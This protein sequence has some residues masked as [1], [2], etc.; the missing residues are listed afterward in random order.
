MFTKYGT[1][2]TP[3]FRTGGGRARPESNGAGTGN[4]LPRRRVGG[5]PN[6]VSRSSVSFGANLACNSSRAIALCLCFGLPAEVEKIVHVPVIREEQR[7]VQNPVEVVVEVPQPQ[8][9]VKVVEVPKITVEEKIIKVPKI[10]HTVVDTATWLHCA[11]LDLQDGLGQ[12]SKVDAKW[13][14][15]GCTRG[16]SEP[17]PGSGGG[18]ADGRAQDR[19][20]EE[21]HHSG[22]DCRHPKGHW[23]ALLDASCFPLHVWAVLGVSCF[24]QTAKK[25]PK[26]AA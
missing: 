23:L 9:V 25:A 3:C 15:S 21:T 26:V 16:D 1:C 4:K 6:R 14:Q 22:G 13:M 8:V 20:E 5:H 11:R 18:E 7:I 2:V 24:A 12:K 10:T 17:A 19:A